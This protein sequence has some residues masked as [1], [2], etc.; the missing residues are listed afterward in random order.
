MVKINQE[1]N[2][3][4]NFGYCL[5]SSSI[6]YVPG[7]PIKTSIV[8]S[9]YWKFKNNIKVFILVSYRNLKGDLIK[10][11]EINFEESSVTELNIP[12][13]LVGSCEV[14]AFSNEDLRIPYSAIMVV[15]EGSK[16]I[17]MV[18]SYSRVYSP[19]EIEDKK[20][21]C[22]GNEG[23]WVLKDTNQIESFAVMH[24]GS[25][26]YQKQIIK[27]TATNYLGDCKAIEVPINS[28]KPYQT[29]VIKPRKYFPDICEFL[30][31][32]EGSCVIQFKVSNS[33]TRLLLGWLTKDK[34]QIQVTHSNFD[35]SIHETNLIDATYN[36]GHMQIPNL[37]NK[38][39]FALIYPDRSPGHYSICSDIMDEIPIQENLYSFETKSQDIKF[40]RNDGKLPAR[41]VTALK[42]K[43]EDESILPCECSLGIKHILTPPKRFHWGIWS[44]KFNSLLIISAFEKLYGDPHKAKICLRLYSQKTNIVDEKNLDWD[45]ITTDGTNATLNIKE[46]FNPSFIDPNNFM[47]ISLF[48]H[49][50]G[51]LAYTTLHKGQSI[52]IE[53]TF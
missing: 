33:F 47:Y 45:Q 25:S 40:K 27:L 6:F 51:F 13:D 20:T 11:E 9:D 43:S 31:G 50:G 14:E 28:L 10:R 26:A 24:N 23:C 15:Y 49:Y 18:H 52:S 44:S 30:Q 29:V 37:S 3:N 22:D 5:R 21:I 16:S 2:Y 46:I 7:K 32:R 4:A 34:S 48:S 35:Y 17:S 39:V 12:N 19:L 42:I 36:Y 1:D 38:K 41:I 53:H 8:L